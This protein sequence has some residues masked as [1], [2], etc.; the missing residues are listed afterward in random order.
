MEQHK[1]I[2][3]KMILESVYVSLVLSGTSPVQA[4]DFSPLDEAN[5]I[6]AQ[7]KCGSSRLTGLPPRLQEQPLQ[8]VPHPQPRAALYLGHGLQWTLPHAFCIVV[9]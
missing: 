9:L 7:M 4:T 8:S 2:R 5:S 3:N 1:Q 6:Q